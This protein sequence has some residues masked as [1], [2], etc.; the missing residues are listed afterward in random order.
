MVQNM[1]LTVRSHYSFSYLFPPIYSLAPFV[2]VVS[3]YNRRLFRL[4]ASDKQIWIRN[5]GAYWC[6]LD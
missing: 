6:L 3:S 4:Y 1:L 5:I 2:N